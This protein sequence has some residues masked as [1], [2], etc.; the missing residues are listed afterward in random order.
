MLY[1][2]IQNPGP[3]SYV[4]AECVLRFVF[5]GKDDSIQPRVDFQPLRTDGFGAIRAH[6]IATVRDTV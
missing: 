6:S 3:G 1:E 4:V 5:L 2:L